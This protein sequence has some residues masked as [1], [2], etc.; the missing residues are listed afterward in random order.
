MRGGCEMPSF[1]QGKGGGM[2]EGSVGS[3]E[4]GVRAS[5]VTKSRAMVTRSKA[6]VFMRRT[7]SQGLYHSRDRTW[8]TG[9]DPRLRET[10]ENGKLANHSVWRPWSSVRVSLLPLV[11]RVCHRGH[12]EVSLRGEDPWSRCPDSPSK[13]HPSRSPDDRYRQRYFERRS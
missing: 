10:R 13:T 5:V 6:M 2:E 7:R 12:L 9:E 11:R 1:P 4:V 8:K 3:D